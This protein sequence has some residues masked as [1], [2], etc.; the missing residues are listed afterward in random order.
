MSLQFWRRRTR[1]EEAGLGKLVPFDKRP[2]VKTGGTGS[3]GEATIILFT[4]V[5]Y[6]RSGTTL[7]DKG[8]TPAKPGR[9]R[10]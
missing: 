2:R 6:E 5:R 4:G 9:K 10:G 8:T 7:P 1:D 3:A